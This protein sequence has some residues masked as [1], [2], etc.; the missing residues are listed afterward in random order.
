MKA[1]KSTSVELGV[2]NTGS[3]FSSRLVVFYRNIN[4]G[5]DYDYVRYQYFNFVKQN[6]LGVEYETNTKYR[7][8]Q[9]QS[10]LQ[11]LVYQ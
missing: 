4:N 9:S 3:M 6:V 11:L 1:E 2:S 5:I 7:Q 10:Q 8:D